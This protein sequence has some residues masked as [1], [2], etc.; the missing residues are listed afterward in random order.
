V[1]ATETHEFLSPEWIAAV[2]AIRDEYAGRVPPP[3]VVVRANVVVTDTPFP[4]G[5]VH[6]FV[7][8]SQ[9]FAIESGR[10]DA[11]D[12]T[13]SHDYE[14][15]KALFVEQDPQALLQAFFGGKIRLTGDAS[16]LLAMPL[17]KPG[18]TGPAVD[19]AREVADRVRAITA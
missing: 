8:T 9:G 13:A 16:K 15:A 17:P 14:T 18:D 3:S 12:F 11:P 5:D 2:P 10:I 4:D 19:F 7:D 1:S 6:G